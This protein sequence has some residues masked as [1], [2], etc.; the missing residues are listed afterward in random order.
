MDRVKGRDSD[1][2]ADT[3][4]TNTDSRGKHRD[5]VKRKKGVEIER[6]EKRRTGRG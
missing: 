3:E 6:R 5:K 4:D 2:K 1:K